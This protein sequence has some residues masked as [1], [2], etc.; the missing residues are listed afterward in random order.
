MASCCCKMETRCSKESTGCC[1]AWDFSSGNN[2]PAPWATGIPHWSQTT[3]PI[4][5]PSKPALSHWHQKNKHTNRQAQ[6]QKGGSRWGQ[7]KSGAD[8]QDRHRPTCLTKSWNSLHKLSH[9]TDIVTE[10]SF[11]YFAQNLF[12]ALFHGKH[13]ENRHL[14]HLP[15]PPT[16]IT[17]MQ[18]V[19]KCLDFTSYF[20]LTLLLYNK[21]WAFFVSH[22]LQWL[23]QW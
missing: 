8:L 2:W 22:H 14:T 18:K 15:P 17:Y 23:H 6:G 13:T 9:H 4:L 16:A 5:L 11:P 19:C 1:P 7:L 12:F 10:P 21:R 20:A 3:N